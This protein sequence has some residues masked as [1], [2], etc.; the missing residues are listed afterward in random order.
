MP[1]VSGVDR[2]PSVSKLLY[3]EQSGC[4]A[5]RHFPITRKFRYGGIYP[6]VD[7][8]LLRQPRNYGMRFHR[9]PPGNDPRTDTSFKIEGSEHIKN[10]FR[11][12][13]RNHHVRRL[14]SILSSLISIKTRTAHAKTV[15][16]SYYL[17]KN[18]EVGF[19]V[20][21][22]RHHSPAGD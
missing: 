11:W 7:L 1:E 19:S 6:G 10:R 20:G 16:G 4:V 8:A 2:L 12:P 21:S 22:V 3:R 18:N 13:H 9:G 15:L 17:A 14:M 5:C